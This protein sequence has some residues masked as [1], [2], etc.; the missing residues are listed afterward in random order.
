MTPN[1]LQFR[2]SFQLSLLLIV[3]AGL[4]FQPSSA[5]AEDF[6]QELHD[7]LVRGVEEEVFP[8]AV[9]VVG[10]TEEILYETAVGRS[11]YDDDATT[12]AMDT[13]F[14]LASVSK[15]AGTATASWLLLEE[16]RLQLDD[17]VSKYISGFKEGGKE[18]V[19]IR[20]LLTHV[21]GL[22]AYESFKR[23]EAKRTK[24]E[25][26]ADALIRHYAA[27]PVSYTPREDYKYSCLN[28]QSMARVNE[29]V[30]EGRMEP[31]LAQRVWEPLGMIDTGY[32]LTAEQKARCA[33]TQIR[34]DGSV[35]VAETHDPLANYHGSET[36]CPGNAGLFST[37]PDLA[38]YCQM[39][40]NNGK[41]DGKQILSEETL[42]Q[43][44]S[45]QTP[46]QLKSKR[47]LGFVIYTKEP[48]AT[49]ENIAP[50]AA[51]VGH[52]GYTGTAFYIDKL[53]GFY[54]VLFTNRTYPDDSRKPADQLS[55][56]KVRRETMRI[57][58]SHFE[59]N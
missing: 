17:N 35:I 18:D 43:A 31:F 29:T 38:K 6:K 44:T 58:R 33:P 30:L 55:I 13:I 3:S 7:L 53:H 24:G 40:L 28:F 50:D 21:S 34:E 16:G 15:V 11:T 8:G 45:I 48:Y 51:V 20:D 59:N 10:T 14:D 27:L 41:W 46:E 36:H 57:A 37:A 42:K 23:V 2:R 19:T 39:I 9:V 1:R 12:M 52:T 25:T 32:L 22:K 47:G 54:V 49:P 56:G 5:S 4:L 26:H